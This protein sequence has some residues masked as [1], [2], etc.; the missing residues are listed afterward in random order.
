MEKLSALQKA[1]LEYQPKT[2]DM[3]KGDISNIIAEESGITEPAS[4]KE[5]IKE[6]FANVYGLPVVKFKKGSNP[7]ANNKVNVGIVLS[8]GQAPGGHNVIIGV[9]DALKKANKDSKLFG[10][11]GGPSGILEDKAIEITPEFAFDFRNTGG[12]DMIGSGR[13][14]LESEE[15]FIKCIEVFKKRQISALIIVGGDDS[16]TNAALLAEYLKKNNTGVQVIGVPKTIDGDLKNKYIETS[17]GFDTATKVYSELIGNI[18]RD[19]NSAKKYWHFIKLM[20]RS[21][22][23]IGLEC[24]LQTQ[25]NVAIISEEVEKEHITLVEIVDDIVRIII[26]R[27]ENKE[28]FGVALIPEGLIE[29]IPEMKLLISELN[30]LL[31][32]NVTHFETLNSFAE[33]TQWINKNLSRDSSFVFSSL[34]FDI[35]K[36]LLMDRDP[37]GNVQVSRIET[38]KLIIDLVQDKLTEMKNNG[39]FKGKFSAQ[40]HFFGYEGRCAAP[41]N[42][43]SDYCYS[44]GYTAFILIANGLTGYMSS[45]SNLAQPYTNWAAGGIPLTMMMTMEQRRGKLKPVIKK[46]LVELDGKPFKKFAEQREEC[47]I[48]TSF[49]YPGAVQYYG[50]AEV[51]DRPTKTLILE[52]E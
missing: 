39:K 26:T 36:Q 34:P 49:I 46:A 1:R 19:A 51:C 21:A 42:F 33:Q 8:G 44:L 6:L 9:L 20:G 15:Q 45:V 5:E 24:A 3:I 10:F 28:D 17:F 37:H 40:N 2:P 30:D 14:K 18:C 4:F 16:N 50:P 11:L 7:N 41:S 48:K 35:Q 27:S 22:S 29:F 47:A 23:H 52:S 32:N 43:D 31:A 25:P 38:E 13:T 12:F